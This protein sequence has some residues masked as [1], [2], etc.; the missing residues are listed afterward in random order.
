MGRRHRLSTVAAEF[1]VDPNTIVNYPGNNFDLTQVDS[2]GA[3]IDPG[4]WLIV[5]G[6]WRPIKDWGPPAITRDNPATA[7]YYGEGACGAVY[8]GA[9]GAGTFVWPTT[10][11]G[12]SGYGCDPGVHPAIDISGTEGN[13][14]FATDSGV[15]FAGWSA[16]G[17]GLLIV[18]DH[19]NGFSAYAH[20]VLSGLRSIYQGGYIGA[21]GNT[22]IPPLITFELYITWCCVNP[23]GYVVGWPIIYKMGVRDKS[24]LLHVHFLFQE[25]H[26]KDRA[27]RKEIFMCEGD[28]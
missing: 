9:I 5:P 27:D 26:L 14:V 4:T 23:L 22:G 11:R 3:N 13:S 25:R 19:G 28:L 10:D 1:K 21:L 2:D 20:G 6:G 7:S 8:T 16:Y 15:T 12:V 18:V 17:Y 24:N